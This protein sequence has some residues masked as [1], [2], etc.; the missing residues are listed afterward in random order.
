MLAPIPGYSP[1]D[2]IRFERN[3]YCIYSLGSRTTLEYGA[4]V[5]RLTDPMISLGV[6]ERFACLDPTW[7]VAAGADRSL[8]PRLVVV[9]T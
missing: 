5:A 9:P 8:R 6:A 1:L 7:I 4:A 2:L 3:M